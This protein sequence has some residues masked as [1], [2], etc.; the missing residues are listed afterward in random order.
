MA[1]VRVG[2]IGVGNMGAEHVKILHRL[3]PRATVTM[4]A[5]PDQDRARGVAAAV[6]ARATSDS[7]A[8]I[9]DPRVDAIVIASPDASHAGL[10]VAAIRAGKPV[11]CEKPLAPTVDECL[12][13]VRAE[14]RAGQPLVSLGFMRRFDPAYV[15]LRTELAA[16]SCG[17][18]LMVRCASRTVSFDPA[19]SRQNSITGSAVHDFDIVPWLLASPVTEVAWHAPRVSAVASFQDPQ[20]ILLHTERGVLAVVEL[21]LNARYGYDIRCE[22]VGDAGA[23]SIARPGLLVTDAA[24]AESTAFPADWRSRFADA[25]RLEL[26]AWIDAVVAG[27]QPTLATARDGL[28]A[29]VVAQAVITSMNDGGRTVT[30]RPPAG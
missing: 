15:A 2:V 16:G 5:G 6:G 23:V 27:G 22:V 14:Q 24:R 17:N 20:L 19:A 18:P 7:Y 21:F 9:A 1:D 12:R 10:A 30:V 28:T 29:A 25:Y 26:H 4:V 3:V 13:V 11:M 8:L